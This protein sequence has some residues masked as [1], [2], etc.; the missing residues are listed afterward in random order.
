MI[1]HFTLSCR[2]LAGSDWLKKVPYGFG[3]L[4]RTIDYKYDSSKYPIYVTENGLSSAHKTANPSN[5]TD[6]DPVLDDQF[7]IDF[8]HQYIGQM[9]KAMDEGVN[10]KAYTAWSL[11]DNFEWSNGYSERFGLHWTNF[12]DDNRPVYQKESAKWFGNLAV[13]N[14][15]D[16]FEPTTDNAATVTLSTIMALLILFN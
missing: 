8:Y 12:T 3:D 16:S 4:L 13:T 15:L 2:P 7:R 10:V 6:F 11:V 14:K 5:G 9:K 1:L